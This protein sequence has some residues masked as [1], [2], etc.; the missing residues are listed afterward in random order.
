M[1]LTALCS[2]LAVA[3][4]F[5]A[6]TVNAAD[7][8]STE[9]EI[10]PAVSE[11]ETGISTTFKPPEWVVEE[12][13]L[14]GFSVKKTVLTMNVGE[15]FQLQPVWDDDYYLEETLVFQSDNRAVAEVDGK[16]GEIH[17]LKDGTAVI[18]IKA[19]L[20]PEKVDIQLGDDDSRT[21][22]VALTVVNPEMSD[23]Q[24]TALK[25]L[26]QKGKQLVGQ[27]PHAKAVITGALAQDT[28]RLTLEDAERIIAESASFPEIEE[29]ISALQPYPD[30]QGSVGSSWTEYWLDDRG[31]EKIM[32]FDTEFA[33]YQRVYQD[34][35]FREGRFIYERKPMGEYD[36]DSKDKV[37]VSY[38]DIPT[39]WNVYGLDAET[40][41]LTMT[42]GETCQLRAV[43]P[44]DY[45]LADSLMFDCS[46]HHTA[47]TFLDG[48]ISA[49]T[50]GT[51]TVSVKAKLD[52]EK[53]K[54]AP[55]DDG[56][57]KITVTVKVNDQTDLTDAQKAALE[58]LSVKENCAACK[59]PNAK[60]V[61]KG[62][63]ATDAPR[64]TL[65]QV[66]QFIEESDSTA[67]LMQKITDAA[68]YP[69]YVGGSGF[70][71]FEYWFDARGTE[72]I[73]VDVPNWV[74]SIIYTKLDADGTI[75]EMRY[76]YPAKRTEKQMAPQGKEWLYTFYN[77]IRDGDLYGDANS[78]GTVDVSDAV[79]LARYLAED[80]DAQLTENGRRSADANADD[81]LTSEDVIAILK[82]IAKL[83]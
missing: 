79:L 74:D 65:E 45:Y 49:N 75:R 20:N 58:Q 24:R 83:N 38:N 39:D 35:S 25:E 61:I 70:L 72:K 43:L 82:T 27:F 23:A 9:N 77:D 53:V 21:I 2:A 62:A 5:C 18:S 51:A 17:A 7:L 3:A 12:P 13:E 57:R 81:H 54:L 42:V 33:A 46:S 29:K 67:E 47:M 69:D 16:T 37:F 50:A 30:F 41:E 32:L 73:R 63:L 68:P 48:F 1:K 76:L 15:T 55:D 10:P 34:G 59:F 52:P 14:Y 66:S 40:P 56:S 80:T 8:H 31:I 26:E 64:L 78:D 71:S 44:T 22:S 36:S 4:S 60:A 6:L 28:P 11:D 19:K